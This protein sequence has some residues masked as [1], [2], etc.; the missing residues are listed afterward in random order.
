MRTR[1][2]LCV[3][4]MIAWAA[5]MPDGFW[6]MSHHILTDLLLDGPALLA[7]D[8]LAWL[9]L[10]VPVAIWLAQVWLVPLWNARR[11]RGGGR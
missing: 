5:R 6:E 8:P 7:G 1:L 4:K 11:H 2:E 9:V 3:Y 10:C